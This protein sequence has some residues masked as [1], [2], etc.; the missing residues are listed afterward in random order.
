MKFVFFLL[1]FLISLGHRV[2][3]LRKSLDRCYVE[4]H[5]GAVLGM[6]FDPVSLATS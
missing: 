2:L 6:N 4:L 1:G 5:Y 3:K